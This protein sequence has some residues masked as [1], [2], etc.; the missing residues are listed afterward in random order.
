MWK[1]SLIEFIRKVFRVRF[2][3]LVTAATIID[4]DIG[5][6][7]TSIERFRGSGHV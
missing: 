7:G 3:S 6:E 5:K 4:V 1:V 2:R